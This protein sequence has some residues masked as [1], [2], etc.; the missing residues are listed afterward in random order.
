MDA[1]WQ[2]TFSLQFA[3]QKL[4]CVANQARLAPFCV[5]PH[6]AVAVENH[7]SMARIAT[8]MAAP[9]NMIHA[10]KAKATTVEQTLALDGRKRWARIMGH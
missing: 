7:E 4:Q 9:L 10:V 2:L 1:V 3:V 5:V 8:T 6:A